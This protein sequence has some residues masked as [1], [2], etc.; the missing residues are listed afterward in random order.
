MQSL[1]RLHDSVFGLVSRLLSPWFLPT[2]ARLSFASVLLL[3]FWNSGKTKVGENIFTPSLGAYAQIFPKKMEAL[4][5]DP[6]LMSN[7]DVLVVLM[8]TYAE[9]VLPA[10]VVIG[11]F[12]RLASLGM[13]GFIIVMTIVDITG[14]NVDAVTIGQMFDRQPFGLI[15]D[16]RLLWLFILIIPVI[17]GPGPISVD[18]MLS[19]FKK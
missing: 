11:L 7:F 3:F 8:G 18:Y 16:Q 13:I 1:I 9:F 10:M 19:K 5:Y 17:N 4:G 12:T 2:A 6:S 15:A 14:H